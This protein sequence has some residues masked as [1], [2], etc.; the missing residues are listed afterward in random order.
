VKVV[1]LGAGGHGRV[2]AETAVAAGFEVRAFCDAALETGS[3]VNGI[4]VFEADTVA[5]M[6]E[7][8]DSSDVGIVVAIGDNDTRMKLLGEAESLGYALPVIVHPSAVM[9]PSAEIGPG[10]VVIANSVVNANARIGK[11]CILNTACSIDHDNVLE[12]GVQ[13]CPGVRSAGTVT[14][15]EKA[16]IGTGAI[17]VPGVRIGRD[18]HVAAGAL[19]ISDVADNQKIGR[20]PSRPAR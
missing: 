20:F 17:L 8:F 10:T 14:F 1:V 2:C 5:R 19:V 11:G 12:D 7:T 3:S 18:A 13:I 6:S 4:E 15:G 16:F 9:S